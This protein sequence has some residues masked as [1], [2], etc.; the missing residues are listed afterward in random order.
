MR[1]KLL[2][3]FSTKINYCLYVNF[4]LGHIEKSQGLLLKNLSFE[5]S[6]PTHALLFGQA[7]AREFSTYCR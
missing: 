2:A 3:S 6:L 4:S 7:Y 1:L 5:H